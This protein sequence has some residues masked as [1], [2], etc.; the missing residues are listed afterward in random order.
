MTA[1]ERGTETTSVATGRSLQATEKRVFG[2]AA[3]METIHQI[4]SAQ[5]RGLESRYPLLSIADQWTGVEG[6]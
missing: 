3:D 2:V 1:M 6:G 5:A 4:V